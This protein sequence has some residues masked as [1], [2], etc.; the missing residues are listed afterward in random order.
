MFGQIVLFSMLGSRTRPEIFPNITGVLPVMG[1]GLAFRFIGWA[2][3]M[4]ITVRARPPSDAAGLKSKWSAVLHHTCF[5]FLSTVPR[6]TI[7][8][9]LGGIA[10]KSKFFQGDSDR[11]HVEHFIGLSAKLYIVSLAVVGMIL[12]NTF[13]PRLLEFDND[14]M[15]S[16]PQ[17]LKSATEL[18]LECDLM[19]AAQTL[20]LPRDQL[21]SAFPQRMRDKVLPQHRRGRAE[22]HQFDGSMTPTGTSSLAS[23]GGSTWP[24]APVAEH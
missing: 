24:L 7:Q 20:S 1:V 6:A 18:E 16:A 9:A 5:C 3:A 17:L 10:L 4:L 12:L 21:M 19:E 13:G 8:G 22:T 2:L 14:D 23:V 11:L 15:S